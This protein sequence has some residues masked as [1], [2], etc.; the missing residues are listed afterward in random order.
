MKTIVDEAGCI[1]LPEDVRA[2]LGVKPGDE[3][4]LEA[5]AGEW[6]LKAATA[7]A[8]LAWEGNVLVHQGTSMTSPTIESAIEELRNERF[9][10]LTEGFTS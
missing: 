10:Q 5:R 2:Q 7:K 8:G 4:L 6:V 3:V 1:L 9:Q